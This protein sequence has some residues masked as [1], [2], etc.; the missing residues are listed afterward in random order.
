MSSL[1]MQVR[2]ILHNWNRSIGPCR[3]CPFNAVIHEPEFARGSDRA[4]IM[5]VCQ[6]P[7]KKS[8]RGRQQSKADPQIS[9]YFEPYMRAALRENWLGIRTMEKM[10]A[11]TGFDMVRDVYYTNVCKCRNYSERKTGLEDAT[12]H[13]KAYLSREIRSL[14]PAVVVTFGGPAILATDDVLDLRLPSRNMG[15]LHRGTFKSRRGGTVV[16][17]IRHWNW[18][19]EQD[20][21]GKNHRDFER[22]VGKLPPVRRRS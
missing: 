19:G 12:E 4:T 17:A 7:G 22:T 15:D 14:R 3:G 5:I 6:N 21:A 18:N 13:C 16:L 2:R 9:G 20:Y 1:R 8:K 11:G 10:I